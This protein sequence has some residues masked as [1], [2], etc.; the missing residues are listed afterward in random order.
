MN[1]PEVVFPDEWTAVEGKLQPV[2]GLTEGIRPASLE[3]WIQTALV[4][5]KDIPET[6]PVDVRQQLGLRSR[7][8]VTR[9][10]HQSPDQ[11]TAT[12]VRQELAFYG[13]ARSAR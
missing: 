10:A 5:V 13:C 2:Y 3:R 9:L 7:A 11:E 8:E 12:A 6:L 1:S 4:A